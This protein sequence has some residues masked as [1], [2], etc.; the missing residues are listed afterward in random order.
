[1]KHLVTLVFLIATI[2]STA[3]A[4]AD[5]VPPDPRVK[6][7]VEELEL[8]RSPTAMRTNPAWDPKRVVVTLPEADSLP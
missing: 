7:I 2:T 1:M 4:T 5:S 6:L 3:S 8:Q